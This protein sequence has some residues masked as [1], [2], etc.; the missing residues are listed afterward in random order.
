MTP[1]CICC[2]LFFFFFCLGW[3]FFCL[4]CFHIVKLFTISCIC[5]HYNTKIKADPSEGVK[6][7][8]LAW[9][10]QCTMMSQRRVRGILWQGWFFSLPETLLSWFKQVGNS[11]Y[12][13]RKADRRKITEG[14]KNEVVIWQAKRNGGR[15]CK[16]IK[17]SLQCVEVSKLKY[18][19][20]KC[21]L[22][23]VLLSHRKRGKKV[24]V[25]NW[26]WP[27][28]PQTQNVTSTIFKKR[29]HQHILIIFY[30]HLL[31]IVPWSLIIISTLILVHWVTCQVRI[32]IAIL[33][34]QEAILQRMLWCKDPI[35]T[36]LQI[37]EHLFTGCFL[38]KL[39][40]ESL[41]SL[42]LMP[43]QS[44]PSP[45]RSQYATERGR[46]NGSN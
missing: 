24:K 23:H 9:N 28:L 46:H 1:T 16:K 10:A 27:R 7:K 31:W 5:I 44:P 4:F 18:I 30:E 2:E 11:S 13:W 35:Q 22:Q 39:W 40:P 34:K 20:L 21:S 41:F 17:P 19:F 12:K 8:Q 14:K 45:F 33:I 29:G 38:S 25:K 42:P 32:C 26:I 36:V 3:G 37:S 6:E 15:Y 43:A